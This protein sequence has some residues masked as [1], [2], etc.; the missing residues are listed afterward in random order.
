[1]EVSSFQAAKQLVQSWS[2]LEKDA[3]HVYV[4]LGVFLAASLLSRRTVRSI[5]PWLTV[6]GVALLG[7]GLDLRDGLRGFGHWRWTDSVHDILNTLFWPTVMVVL[8]R[9]TSVLGHARH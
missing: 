7:E 4:G 1:M 6:L 9:S 3:L 8:G 2:G 5:L